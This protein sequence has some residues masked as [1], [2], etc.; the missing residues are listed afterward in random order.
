VRRDHGAEVEAIALEPGGTSVD[1]GRVD[2]VGS[3]DEVEH[4]GL[5]EEVAVAHDGVAVHE[6]VGGEGAGVNVG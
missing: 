1:V 5:G 6:G 3:G 4:G 2:T